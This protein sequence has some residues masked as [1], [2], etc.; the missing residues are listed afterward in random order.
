MSTWPS[1]I[2]QKK[3]NIF[4][5]TSSCYYEIMHNNKKITKSTGQSI[6]FNVI[7]YKSLLRGWRDG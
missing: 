2:S 5:T 4:Q 6:D 1:Y 3:I 7:A